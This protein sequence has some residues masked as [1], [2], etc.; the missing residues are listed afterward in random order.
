MNVLT[1]FI[2]KH[3]FLL[4]MISAVA[5]ATAFPQIGKS[6]GPM[7]AN[8]LANAGVALIFFFHGMTL[9]VENLKNGLLSW[10]VHAAVQAMTFVVFPL[11][12]FVL[13]VPAA[14]FF[15]P[16]L[17]LG[18][19]FLGALP[20]TISSSVAMVSIARGNVPAAIFNASF[21]N[22]IG[23]FVTPLLLGFF[24]RTTGDSLPLGETVF[25]LFNLLFLPFVLGQIARIFF[26]KHVPAVKPY[27]NVFDSS[28]ILLIV[29]SSFSDAVSQ[30]LWR[31]HGWTVLVQ[32]FAGA[33][34]VL[35]AALALSS[36]VSKLFK[37]NKEDEITAVFCGS[38]KTLASGIPI[39]KIVFGSAALA[40][41]IN[42]GL[43]VLP[44]M[45]YHQLQIFVC[46]ILADRYAK[47]NS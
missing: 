21:S 8:D 10:K 9:S 16:G 25:K 22:L 15:S 3:W 6:D 41:D 45:F 5:L 23:I 24:A 20:S 29:F 47:R 30:G 32:T 34:L 19:Y 26:K 38:K 18:F 36:G 1:T 28:V 17:I 7:R 43:L 31:D 44:I 14:H 37:F 12:I 33:A 46:S 40:G 13:C 35:A 39:A 42:L 4:G 2:K 27:I 11:M